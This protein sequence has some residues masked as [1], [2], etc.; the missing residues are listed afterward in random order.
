MRPAIEEKYTPRYDIRPY[1]L[2]LLQVPTLRVPID[3]LRGA[4][5]FPLVLEW[6][7]S[8]GVFTPLRCPGCGA[9]A[10]EWPLVVAKTHLGCARC[11]TKTAAGTLAS[12]SSHASTRTSA[13]PASAPSRG[14]KPAPAAAA[15]EAGNTVNIRQDGPRTEGRPGRTARPKPG[16]STPR[17]AASTR[18]SP[19]AK[20]RLLSPQ[21]LSRMGEKMA[22]E[23][24]SVTG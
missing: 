9:D 11:L 8:A 4:R 16:R 24:W 20:A 22:M 12:Q 7:L 15:G 3:V 10:R 13:A 21:A 1:R 2:H 17:A 18:M 6:L 14:V 5:R 23:L 19:S